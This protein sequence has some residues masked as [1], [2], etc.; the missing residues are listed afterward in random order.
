[1]EPKTKLDVSEAEAAH[2]RAAVRN[3]RTIEGVIG[4][5]RLA[6]PDDARFV[7]ALLKDERVSAAVY[8]LPR[9]FSVDSIT[10]WIKDHQRQAREGEG[11]LTLVEDASGQVI[12]I[13][14][15]QFWPQYSA[16][17][18]GGVIAA[19]LQSKSYGT[20]GIRELCDWCFD[21]IGVRLLAMTSALDNV[22]SNKIFEG[23]GFTHMGEM[24]SVRSDGQVRRS[25][26]WELLKKY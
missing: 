11:L 8:T 14:D 7:L 13:S 24:D 19:H 6:I 2:I 16:C 23:M 25:N 15:F 12:S 9:P 10:D 21:V 4:V 20:K 26:Y 5:S 17:E 3:V 18:F 22:R 1:M